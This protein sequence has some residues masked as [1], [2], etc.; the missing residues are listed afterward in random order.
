MEDASSK[1]F[2]KKTENKVI[3]SMFNFFR[4]IIRAVFPL[5]FMITAYVFLSGCS[6]KKLAIRQMADL[7]EGGFPAYLKETDPLLVKDAM[8]ANLKL[9]DA[10]LENDPE[11]Q[12]LLFLACQGYAAYAFM[13][14]EEENPVR[15]KSLYT[16][17]R[18]YGF[19]MLK[20]RGMLPEK[21][22]DLPSWEETLSHASQK[23]VPAIFWT[24]FAW[25]GMIQTDRESP[26]AIADLP[27]VI[28][29][30][31]QAQGLDP[32]YWFAGPDTFLG[33]YHGSLPVM[34]GG[35][36]DH[37]KTHFESALSLTQ[38]KFLMIQ[39][40]YA[41]SY[42]VQ[43]Q[44]RQLFHSLLTEVI[45]TPEDR[46]SEAALSNAIARQKAA[47]LLKKTDELFQ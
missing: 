30:V 17:A 3:E 43:V 11:N 5:F 14:I 7:M 23:D 27:I 20:H 34:L 31:E 19:A 15:A 25:G 32:S 42:A 28:Q 8:P 12:N 41:K 47:R 13:F 37:A 45:Q 29:L 6:M 40:M 24:A 9:L 10:M 1:N 22:F 26:L 36:P 16:R 2:C 39:V 46:L 44:D 35:K 38:R 18:E 4:I 33:F 21:Q